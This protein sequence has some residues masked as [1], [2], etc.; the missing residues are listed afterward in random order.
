[1]HPAVR[2]G[3]ML[4]V[5][6][7]DGAP[8]PGSVV[9]ALPDNIPDLLRVVETTTGG[10]VLAGDA[11]PS[12]RLVLPADAVLALTDLP[13]RRIGRL[14]RVARRLAIDLHEAWDAWTPG[15]NDPAE[16]VRRKYD[17]QAPFYGVDRPG[18]GT[19]PLEARVR[20]AAPAGGR[21][22]VAGSGAGSECFRLEQIGFEV[23]G[24]DF[25]SRMVALARE[26]AA[27]RGSRVRFVEA[28]LRSHE[29]PNGTLDAVV[30]TFD[31][32]SFI[33]GRRTR[34]DILSRMRGWLRPAGVIYLSARRIEGLYSR[35][36]LTCSLLSRRGPRGRAFGDTNTRWLGMDGAIRRSFVKCFT[37]RSLAGEIREAGLEAG[38]WDA[39][40]GE[41]RAAIGRPG[42][43]Q[44]RRAVTT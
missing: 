9:L 1:M 32:Y 31:V 15:V 14:R 30:F 8:L 26:Q 44:R 40:H 33:P 35:A 23:L 3:Q 6:P 18:P 17:E 38:D 10:I 11:D 16:S 21:I 42:R 19:M 12:S 24:I 25:S 29:E 28:D 34:V 5:R 37:A 7:V 43:S 39:G 27:R 22:L 13:R 41:L 36:V 20:H 4:E 2:H